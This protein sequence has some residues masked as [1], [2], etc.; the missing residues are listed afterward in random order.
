LEIVGRYRNTKVLVRP[1]DTFINQKNY[2]LDHC[3]C[4][5]VLSIDAD[6]V[7]TDTV[8]REIQGLAFDVAGYHIG[9]RNFLGN[10]EIRHGTWSP[11]YQ[12]RLFRKACGRWGGSNPHESV[13]LRGE[14]R[15]LKSR[16]LHF[17]YRHRA[18][19][20]ERNRR[21]VRML[22]EHLAQRGRTANLA[23]ALFHWLGNF[24][25][26]YL[27]RAGFLDG[28]AGLFLAYHIA[29]GSFLKYW[30]LAKHRRS[31]QIRREPAADEAAAQDGDITREA[32]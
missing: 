17:S 18:E 19:F 11:D 24:L 4:D 14:T 8:I 6:E 13:V 1:F 10:Q 5:W 25:K 29:N 22:A 3:D 16:L 27:L 28:S 26:A 31:R 32:A 9:R 21:Y 20:I 30:L 12:L 2:A 23:V 7:L 15:R